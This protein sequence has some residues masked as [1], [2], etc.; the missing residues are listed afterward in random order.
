MRIFQ[1]GTLD[2]KIISIFS[3]VMLIVTGINMT[4]FAMLSADGYVSIIEFDELDS[5]VAVQR[6][7]V[8]E[9]EEAII[10]PDTLVATVL[11]D[12]EK[13]GDEAAGIASSGASST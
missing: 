1:R 9:G 11:S 13:K 10:F 5:S 2:K 12:G 6:I 7:A 4:S 8:G 3:A